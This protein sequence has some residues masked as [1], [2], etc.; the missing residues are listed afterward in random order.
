MGD[1]QH[2]HGAGKGAAHTLPQLVRDE[3]PEALIED[4]EFGSLQQRPLKKQAAAFAV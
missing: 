3:G 2:R 4:H 1:Y